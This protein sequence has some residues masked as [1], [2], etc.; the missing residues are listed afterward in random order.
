MLSDDQLLRYS[1]QLV[2]PELD[3]TGQ[4]KLLESRVL[5][6]GAG[7]L[8]CPLIVYLA[9]SGVGHITVVDYDVVEAHNLPRQVV[10]DS[11]DIGKQKALVVAD[12][13]SRRY[14]DAAVHAVSL[15]LTEVSQVPEGTFDLIIDATDTPSVGAVLNTYSIDREVPLLYL[16]AVAMEGRLF[17]ARG[18][19]IDQPCLQCYF[20]SAADPLGGCHTL[21]VLAPAV[22]AIALLG[23]TQ[24]LRSLLG[25]MPEG[26][27]CL[28]A[29]RLH[30][31]KLQ[32]AKRD[33]CTGCGN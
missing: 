29:W 8:G 19:E 17:F 20:G 24:V 6:V 9:S 22:G 30:T 14:P 18:Y 15:K 13:L 5:V 28:D 32:V 11:E 3:L 23:A 10:F 27:L 21:G 33:G 1:R 16:A 26:L 4:K 7:G 2:L 31:L 25:E 12:K